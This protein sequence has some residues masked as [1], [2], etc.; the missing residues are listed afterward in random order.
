MKATAK[1][2][3]AD[4]R[5]G[6]GGWTYAPWRGTFYPGTLPQ[7]RELEYA[8]RQ[9]SSIEING[10]FYGLQKPDTFAKWRD[11]TPADF[12]FSLKAPRFTTHR[13]VLGSAGDSIARFLASGVLEL[14][15]KLG[16]IN[17]QL[18]PTKQFD[19]E[20]FRSFLKLLPRKSAG[21]AL[22]H[23]V[24]V[25]HE[26]FHTE[27]FIDLLREHEIAVVMAG[28]S[29]YPQFLDMTAP[30]VYAR[31]MGTKESQKMGYSKKSLD[32]WADRIRAWSKERDVYLYVISG[33]KVRNPAAAT[34]LI[35][36]LT[37]PAAAPLARRLP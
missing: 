9:L 37:E 36:R 29:I 35:Q 17:W 14:R 12:V 26:S 5:I 25:R 20:D 34:A 1:T 27:Q 13:K 21:R 28:D 6:I 22:R 4:V 16:P 7:K 23:A 8:S 30:F 33:D 24:E 10:T 3:K 2:A 18:A 15:E 32:L 11:D 19:P 31:I